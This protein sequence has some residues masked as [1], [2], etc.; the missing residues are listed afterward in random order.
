[1]VTGAKER[2][3]P[4]PD[5]SPKPLFF[6]AML[7]L[8]EIFRR[9]VI[10]TLANHH[11]FAVGGAADAILFGVLAKAAPCVT[12]SWKTCVCK[13]INGRGLVNLF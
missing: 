7:R 11:L 9:L 5:T 8:N 4:T 1:M 12:Y 6:A 3:F 10:N 2:S 13:F